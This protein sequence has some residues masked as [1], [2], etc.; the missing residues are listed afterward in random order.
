MARTSSSWMD[1]LL[2]AMSGWQASDLFVTEGKVPAVRVQGSV[3]PVKRAATNKAELREWIDGAFTKAQVARLDDEGD[4]D[5][6][7]TLDDGRRFRINLSRQRGGTAV[8]ARA[9]PFADIEVEDLGLPP[10]V[11][12]LADL[13]R[14]LVLVT[15][16][17]GSGKSTTLTALV[18]RINRTR[19]VHVVTIEDPIEYVHKDA[20]ARVTQRE[21]GADTQ[22]FSSGLRHVLRQSPDVVMLG[23]IRDGETAA[24][25]IQAA[26][27]GHL[28]LAT[29]HTNDAVQ[30][31]QRLIG[32]FPESQQ[33]E[34][35]L[36]LSLCLEGIVSQ[37]LLPAEDEKGR[38]LAVEL[39]TRTPGVVQLLKERRFDDLV[40]L[41]KS[42]SDP[43]ITTFHRSL[44]RLYDDGKVSHD[45]ARAHATN[46]DEFE[47]HARGMRSGIASV[48]APEA[49]RA[50]REID[51][52]TLLGQA[53]QRGASDLH[54]AVGRPAILRIS[55]ELHSLAMEPLS[56]MDLRVLLFSIMTV[57]QRSQFELDREIDFALAFDKG[58]RFRVNAYYQK[59]EI[60][61]ALRAIPSR[62][63]DAER[64]RIPSAVLELG[65]RPHGLVLVVGPTGAGKTTTL[66]CL[67]DRI[68]HT[69]SCRI[70]TI[71]DPIE[72]VHVGERATVDQREVYADTKSFSSAL[73]YILRQDPDVILVGEMRDF[74]TISMALAAAE[75]G[76]LVLATLHTNDAV[77]TIDRIVDAFPPHQQE[78]ARN[79][80]A[81]SLVAVV[82]QRLLPWAK[83]PTRRVPVFEVM[84][85]NPGIRN[86][87][88]ESKMHQALS[89]M[90]TGRADGMVTMDAA[91]KKLHDDGE[92][93]YEEALRYVRNARVLG[94]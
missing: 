53:L 13:P 79:Q 49:A 24:V 30:S 41:M 26:L 86:L 23:E 31:I 88:R 36:D 62:V 25:A 39:L 85:A 19:A 81:A 1:Q 77:Q 45:V 48:Q 74:E 32:L 46:P 15:G 33:E 65:K 67:V 37:R 66:A 28:I 6:G 51:I 61:C 17:T 38:V 50:N 58:Q 35:A 14:G 20:K 29:L 68:N 21:I 94:G 34:K 76:H 57:R 7:Y 10:A 47:L 59:G 8:V 22:S 52:H 40:D 69:R 90:E 44:L 43:A 73:K 64:L 3:R 16:A 4:L 42:S 54:L 87:I 78:Q 27:T 18:H 91:L 71:E 5:A 93:A 72:Y 2:A 11:A 60:A 75:T 63:P 9:V 70:I 80:L 89:M 56:A 84:V 92:I 83:D 12:Q 55:G 82:S